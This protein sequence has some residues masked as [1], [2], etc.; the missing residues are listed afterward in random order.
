VRDDG[1]GFIPPLH[2]NGNGASHCGLRNMR[3]RLEAVGG[4][5]TIEAAPGHGT[6]ISGR[7]PLD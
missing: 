2:G 1:V 7:L 4:R 6:R 5:L 3:D